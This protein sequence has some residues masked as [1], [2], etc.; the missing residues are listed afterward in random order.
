MKQKEP[1]RKARYITKCCRVSFKLIHNPDTIQLNTYICNKCKNEANLIKG[2]RNIKRKIS[3][4]N[5]I[6]WKIN[7]KKFKDEQRILIS[8]KLNKI[9]NHYIDFALITNKERV[10]EAYIKLINPY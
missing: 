7:Q 10:R 9:H 2:W 3:F 6:D 5:L 4:N 8:N 1:K